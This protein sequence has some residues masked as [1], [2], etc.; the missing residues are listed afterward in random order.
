[1]KR[2]NLLLGFLI[3]TV[4]AV[5]AQISHTATFDPSEVKVTETLNEFGDSVISVSYPS[6]TQFEKDGNLLPTQTINFIVPADAYSFKLNV[7][8]SDEIEIAAPALL[9]SSINKNGKTESFPESIFTSNSSYVGFD[10]TGYFAGE[11]QIVTVQIL[12]VIPSNDLEN[13]ILA[14]NISF[15]LSWTTN[16]E[17]LKNIVRS[18]N[19][20][21]RLRK[22]YELASLV[23]NPES[24]DV[25]YPEDPSIQTDDPL[26]EGTNEYVIITPER[27]VQSFQRLINIYD[28]KG[29]T[30]R[31]YKLEEIL[32]YYQGDFQLTDNPAKI[33]QFIRDQYKINDLQY[34][35]LAGP[36]PEMPCRYYVGD[37]PTDFY[38]SELNSRWEQSNGGYEP[39]SRDVYA[40]VNV[41]RLPVSDIKQIETYIDKLLVYEYQYDKTDI[42][43]LSKAV[44]TRQNNNPETQSYIMDDFNNSVLSPFFD[45]FDA[46]NLLDLSA[47]PGSTLNGN[48]VIN[49]MNK[50]PAVVHNFIGEGNPGGVGIRYTPENGTFG[51]VALQSNPSHYVKESAN[52]LNNLTNASYPG[53]CYSMA[54]LLMPFDKVPGYDVN[55]NFGESY[56]FGGNY[57]GV[58]FLGNTRES[59]IN[60]EK[61]AISNFFYLLEYSLNNQNQSK[62]GLIGSDLLNFAKSTPPISFFDTMMKNVLGDPL[63]VLW[64]GTPTKAD[65][66]LTSTYKG[67][68]F[69]V[70]NLSTYWLGYNSLDMVG[71]VESIQFDN[72]STNHDLK[73]NTLVT[74]FGKN[75]V[76][77]MLPVY[78]QNFRFQY[79][80]Q[81]NLLVN[82]LY[83]RSD[84]D[85]SAPTGNVIFGHDAVVEIN[86]F[87]MVDLDYGTVFESGTQV[88]INSKKEVWLGHFNVPAGAKLHVSAPKITWPEDHVTFNSKADVVLIENGKQIYPK[89][90][91]KL[92]RANSTT[93]PPMVVEGRTW[94]YNANAEPYLVREV[95]FRIGTPVEIDGEEWYPVNRIRMA[96]KQDKYE[97]EEE[98]PV[99]MNPD[100]PW[101]IDESPR[102]MC[103]IRQDGATIHSKISYEQWSEDDFFSTVMFGPFKLLYEIMPIDPSSGY[104]LIY[105]IYGPEGSE[106]EYVCDREF[107]NFDGIDCGTQKVIYRVSEVDEIDNSG[108]NY[109]SYTLMFRGWEGSIKGATWCKS[110]PQFGWIT[111]V[112]V[113]GFDFGPFY[114]TDFVGSSDIFF[115][116]QW[117]F[118]GRNFDSFDLSPCLRYVTDAD[119]NILYEH[120]GGLKLWELTESGV[121]DAWVESE[122]ADVQWYTL[123][124]LKIT[125][126][127]SAGIYIR[128]QGSKTQKVVVR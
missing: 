43:Y 33:R 35:L 119:N 65:Y 24:I 92:S 128:R 74:V 34:V 82:D 116:P 36:Y 27:F 110:I 9:K 88:T 31:I 1:M 123:D 67:K 84:L 98:I 14:K 125:E 109:D 127:T 75:I 93:P 115:A 95:G 81:N 6:L 49:E 99:L 78:I 5:L 29:Y 40:E 44:L 4:Q 69:S 114:E 10:K 52:G 79:G 101:I 20:D 25:F 59:A 60:V 42:S 54:N 2:T 120:I 105:D 45:L 107:I 48:T 89:S 87:G 104:E 103:Y 77:V 100:E 91:K 71:K 61:I 17:A 106:I 111:T 51:V 56:L 73:V 72:N 37:I 102:Q 126:P 64:C 38:Y 19:K 86:A 108:F 80:T 13:L 3:L 15:T 94:W 7:T 21:Y 26:K 113:P 83:A 55:L 22:R 85:S 47:S 122:S 41:G 124:G 11:Y 57:G 30:T 58:L 70:N 66:K 8:T 96:S 76:P 118:G 90:S 68:T 23:L 121:E 46:E 112:P 53:W 32:K 12:P 50:F 39:V 62:K 97:Y 63:T 28:N 16:E 117:T 18:S